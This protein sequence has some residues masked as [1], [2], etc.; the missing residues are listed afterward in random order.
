MEAA[1]VSGMQSETGE[2]ILCV[3]SLNQP[4]RKDGFGHGYF[5]IHKGRFG[6]L[7]RRLK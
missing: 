6:R 7:R 3:D 4:V 5:G 1:N 2:L